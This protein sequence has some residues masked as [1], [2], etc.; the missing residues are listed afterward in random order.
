MPENVEFVH[1]DVAYAVGYDAWKDRYITCF[2]EQE[3]HL[4]VSRL[5]L[6]SWTE[7]DR[8]IR[9]EIAQSWSDGNLQSYTDGLTKNM[10]SHFIGNGDNDG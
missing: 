1:K 6:S 2:H 8:S 3:R 5:G 9:P 7:V 4:I 10:A